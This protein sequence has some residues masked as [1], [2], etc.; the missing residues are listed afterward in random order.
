MAL[1]G[2][3]LTRAM[4]P[5]VEPVFT[6]LAGN[7]QPASP[8]TP[9]R[10]LDEP[11]PM[12]TEA[13]DA[14]AAS[15][16][17]GTQAADD[18]AARIKAATMAAVVMTP[19]SAPAD[20]SYNPAGMANGSTVSLLARGFVKF[21]PGLGQDR[22]QMQLT[23][24]EP[25]DLQRVDRVAQVALGLGSSGN[26]PTPDMTRTGHPPQNGFPESAEAAGLSPSKPQH[27]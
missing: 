16:Q 1:D 18:R 27:R 3:L 14:L 6:L 12:D 17:A 4:L 2:T 19:G 22:P 9:P 24:G 7:P 15:N 23:A 13:R 10:T 25:E 21:A 26:A 8:G 5:P 20:T 11:L